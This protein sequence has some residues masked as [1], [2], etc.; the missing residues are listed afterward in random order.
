[1]PE[2]IP[3]VKL[4]QKNLAMLP[5][6]FDDI[7]VHLRQK[8][9]LRPDL[10]PKFFSTLGLNTARTR[11]EKPGPT[12]YSGPRYQ[13]VRMFHDDKIKPSKVFFLI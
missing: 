12:Y 6:Y 1:M 11:P 8:A 9:S 10:S 5:N 7:F 3:K 4:G 13:S 2:K